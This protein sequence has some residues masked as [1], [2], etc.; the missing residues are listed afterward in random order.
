M[1]DSVASESM[2]EWSVKRV[3]E[4]I[5]AVRSELHSLFSPSSSSSTAT[6]HYNTNTTSTAANSNTAA[7]Q[8][9][10]SVPEEEKSHIFNALD[11]ILYICHTFSVR[12]HST[13]YTT[14]H[15]FHETLT[16][17]LNSIRVGC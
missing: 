11:H 5:C 13:L 3:R 4:L 15:S 6:T 8:V 17:S 9:A 7:S 1:C 2:S 10:M 14:A 12:H 16:H